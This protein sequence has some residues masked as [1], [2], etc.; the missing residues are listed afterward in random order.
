MTRSSCGEDLG[1]CIPNTASASA[2]SKVC[3]SAAPL[4]RLRRNPNWPT[5][6]VALRKFPQAGR[7]ACKL[8]RPDWIGRHGS[9]FFLADNPW[10]SSY[11]HWSK[12]LFKLVDQPPGFFPFACVP[13]S[14]PDGTAKPQATRAREP[15]F[16]ATTSSS[17][18]PHA[19]LTKRRRNLAPKTRKK[20]KH[21][22]KNL[23]G[24]A[25]RSTEKLSATLHFFLFVGGFLRCGPL[26]TLGA[27]V[28][29]Q[30]FC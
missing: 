14:C 27:R 7:D 2:L 17:F 25:S 19:V 5:C 6:L 22:P 18:D 26:V 13:V 9:G 28:S 4:H 20:V 16:S 3:R 23:S 24:Y 1:G 10:P 30:V 29:Q 21:S 15:Q 12:P 11:R 8:L